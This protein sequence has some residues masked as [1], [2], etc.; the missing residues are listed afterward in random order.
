M[1]K[2]R[3]P[4]LHLPR[5]GPRPDKSATAAQP[6]P[7]FLAGYK[8][9]AQY[10]LAAL[11][12][13][14][15]LV[16]F[17]ES[18]RALWEWCSHHGLTGGWSLVWP[19]QLDFFIAAGEIGLFLGLAYGW[20]GRSRVLPWTVTLC[21]LAASVAANVGHAQSADWTFKLTAA[22][23]PVTAT[24][25]L[26]V[27]LAILK[28][29]ARS[30]STSPATP[31]AESDDAAWGGR[32]PSVSYEAWLAEGQEDPAPEPVNAP[33]IRAALATMRTDAARIRYA[34]E[35]IPSTNGRAVT[36]WLSHY[37]CVV[38]L[39]NARSTL[40]RMPRHALAPVANLDGSQHSTGSDGTRHLA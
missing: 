29:I 12:L 19:I 6:A 10:T 34:S 18:Y 14:A 2:P 24:A 36:E 1:F 32:G 40:Q 13:A 3:L 20:S 30:Y 35:M 17:S 23:P 39:D 21:G 8:R 37:G 33:E 26:A 31:Q 5:R 15:S 9:A 11:I 38:Q 7:D 22:V 4:R 25:A 28:M 27:G 16:S